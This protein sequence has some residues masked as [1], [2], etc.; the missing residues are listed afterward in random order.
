MGKKTGLFKEF[1]TPV[2]NDAGKRS[3][4]EI[5]QF[6]LARLAVAERA[7]TIMIRRRRRRRRR[8]L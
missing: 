8:R 4:Y 5:V 3:L 7:Y 1:V 6:L 2:Y